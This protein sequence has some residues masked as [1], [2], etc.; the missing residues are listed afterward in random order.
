M[1]PYEI[2]HSV[3]DSYRGLPVRLR[4]ITG[5][6]TTIYQ[7][8]GYERSTDNP[9]AHGRRCAVDD[10]MEF[11]EL[12]EAAEPGAGMMLC[13]RVHAEQMER[14]T[15]RNLMATGRDLLCGVVVEASDV[16]RNA[17]RQHEKQRTPYSPN[18][19]AR[20]PLQMVPPKL[21]QVGRHDT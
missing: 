2:V 9:L 3:L 1:R 21:R 4:E 12:Y 11:C 20:C 19:K 6:A 18:S 13:N 7:M 16:E 14:F 17:S 10:Y 15:E 8:H 5:K